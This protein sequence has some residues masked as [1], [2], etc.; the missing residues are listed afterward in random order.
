[1]EGG[2]VL[3]IALVGLRRPVGTGGHLLP[4]H[5]R[6]LGGFDQYVIARSPLGVPAEGKRAAMLQLLANADFASFGDGDLR[7][8]VEATVD[9]AGIN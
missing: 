4:R 1:M 7:E 5:R 3:S 2:G 6:H 9:V 8:F